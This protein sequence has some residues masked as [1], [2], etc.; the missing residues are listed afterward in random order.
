MPKQGLAHS[1][2]AINVLPPP[3]PNP[4]EFFRALISV[5]DPKRLQGLLPLLIL[6]RTI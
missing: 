2:S 6:W 1:R 3:P 5:I 4:P